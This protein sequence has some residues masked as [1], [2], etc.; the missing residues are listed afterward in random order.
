MNKKK[1]NARTFFKNYISNI[2]YTIDFGA[3][4][5]A[6][7]CCESARRFVNNNNLLKDPSLLPL[8]DF[9]QITSV[10]NWDLYSNPLMTRLFSKTIPDDSA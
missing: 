10:P 3:V 6:I 5:F 4:R 2:C 1:K 8:S 9:F 7:F